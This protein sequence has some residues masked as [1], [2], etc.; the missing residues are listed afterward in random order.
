MNVHASVS[1]R[2]TA[3]V[4]S[5]PVLFCFRLLR[6]PGVPEV[7]IKGTNKLTYSGTNLMLHGLNCIEKWF[8]F[9]MGID[10]LPL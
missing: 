9:A 1:S 2:N 6:I 8:L 3:V 5:I 10:P 4:G 7:W